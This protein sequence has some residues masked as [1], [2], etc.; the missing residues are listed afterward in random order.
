MKSVSLLLLNIALFVSLSHAIADSAELYFPTVTSKWETISPE[1]AGIKPQKL[2]KFIEYA[3]KQNSTGLIILYE[4]R[5][6]T[7]QNWKIKLQKRESYRGFF[8]EITSDGR[9]IEDVASIQKSIISFIACVA[10]DQ[11][12]LDINQTVSNYIGTGWSRAS[13]SQENEITVRHLLTMSSGLTKTLG[14]QAPA[15]SIWKYNNRAYSK[16]VPILEAAIGMSISRLTTDWLTRP[17][18]MHESRWV[19]R[20]WIKDSHDANKIGFAT[21][22]RDLAKFGL[23]ILANGTWDGHAIIKNPKFLFEALEPSQDLNPNY[24]FLW[25]L[26]AK[27]KNPYVPSDAV[28]ALGYLER[29]VL[30]IPSKRFV[31]VRIGNKAEKNFRRK[32][33]KLFNA[34][35]SK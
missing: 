29:I 17:T 30:V 31:C 23:L 10:R 25:W 16:M 33:S 14:F 13:L 2:Q 12:K 4:G 22:A 26:N 6:L 7:E 35:L 32:F 11:G 5:I 27:N 28:W 18:G 3:K 24:G 34:A 15:G 9:T 1:R 20:K 8:I 21:S 19:S